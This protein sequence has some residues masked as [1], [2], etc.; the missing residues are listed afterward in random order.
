MYHSNMAEEEFDTIGGLAISRNLTYWSN[1]LN[2]SYV[3]GHAPHPYYLS[4]YPYT[5]PLS[6]FSLL[7]KDIFPKMITRPDRRHPQPLMILNSGSAR[8]D[9]SSG[10]F[11]TD[12]QSLVFPFI[13]R[14]LFVPDVPASVAKRV[15]ESM[16]EVGEYAHLQAFYE[17][18]RR[19]PK[20]SIDSLSMLQQLEDEVQHLRLRQSLAAPSSSIGD[21]NSA[22][23]QDQKL[24]FG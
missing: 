10:P 19:Q 18:Q 20:G 22:A 9:I 23:S 2:L 5:S 21:S 15:V 8:F 17:E 7:L 1:A 14:N 11:T 16:N 4:R 6:I 13:N 3:F 12:G 24:T